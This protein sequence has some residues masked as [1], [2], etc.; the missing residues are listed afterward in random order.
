MPREAYNAEEP[1]GIQMDVL[2]LCTTFSNQDDELNKV[3]NPYGRASRAV[4]TDHT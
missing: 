4:C 2:L 3:C 1:V